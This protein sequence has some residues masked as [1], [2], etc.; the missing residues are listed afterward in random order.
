MN[1]TTSQFK[2][3]Y[4]QRGEVSDAYRLGAEAWKIAYERSLESIMASMDGVLPQ[5]CRSV[6]DVGGGM[7][8]LGVLLV[9]RYPAVDY[10]VIDGINDPP[11]VRRHCATFNNAAVASSFLRA[12]GVGNFGFYSPSDALDRKFDLVVS[13]AAWCFHIPPAEYLDRVK[14]ALAPHATIVLDV[15]RRRR[16][17]ASELVTAFGKPKVLEHG[18]KHVRLAWQT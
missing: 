6:L 2:Y 4:V 8:G 1:I 16:D 5:D 13:F 11:E 10:R 9:R 18:K 7:G 12:N 15:R 17:W 14:G 3:L